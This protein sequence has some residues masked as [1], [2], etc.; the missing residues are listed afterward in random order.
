MRPDEGRLWGGAKGALELVR[1]GPL[2]VNVDR[3]AEA[4]G[5]LVGLNESGMVGWRV[6]G[7]LGVEPA[8]GTKLK[9]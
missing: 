6:V 8:T 1:V 3:R 9:G 2:L 5:D 4:T 7:R